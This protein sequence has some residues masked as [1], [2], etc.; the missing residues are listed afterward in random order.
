ML[1]FVFF[2]DLK[3]E[4]SASLHLARK[5]KTSGKLETALKIY[6][7]ALALEPSHPDVLNEYG[8]AIIFYR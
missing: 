2:S 3:G 8:K 5:M 4:I 7:H 1:L 6:E